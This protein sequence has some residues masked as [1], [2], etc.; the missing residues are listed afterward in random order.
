M[1]INNYADLARKILREKSSYK[2]ANSNVEIQTVFDTETN[3]Y[4]ML[5][6]GWRGES[7]VYGCVIHLEIK[8]GKIWIQQDG[9]E[10]G[11]ANEFIAAGVPKQDIVLGWHYPPVRKY[12]E[13]AVG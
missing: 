6:V 12:T 5:H 8:E 13:F 2:P 7:R 9:T 3:R 1:A 11:V 10:N 4:L